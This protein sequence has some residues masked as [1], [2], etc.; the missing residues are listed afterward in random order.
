MMQLRLRSALEEGAIGALIGGV[1]ATLLLSLSVQHIRAPQL[2]IALVAI[3]AGAALRLRSPRAGWVL[4]GPVLA[5]WLVVA[6]TP[7]APWLLHRLVRHDPLAQPVDAVV[8]LSAFVLPDGR[9]PARGLDRLLHGLD[10]VARHEVPILV[11]ST[12]TSARGVSARDDHRRV[13]SLL[14]GGVQL[15]E[16][17]EVWTTRDEAVRLEA[18]A[19]QEGWRRVAVVTS[20]SHTRRACAAVEA[21]GLE[22]TCQPA[23]TRDVPGPRHADFSARLFMAPELTYEGAAYVEYRVRG[24]IRP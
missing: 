11:V 4:L 13:V 16:M 19:R 2:L 1:I 20:P 10:L 8:V 9:L 15:L 7:A 3:I 17:T 21:T 14:G 5:A 18:L 24:W 23:P 12:P 6:A 22:V